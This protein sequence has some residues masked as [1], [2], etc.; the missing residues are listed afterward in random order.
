MQNSAFPQGP[1]ILDQELTSHSDPLPVEKKSGFL[2]EP[3]DEYRF[4][5]FHIVR[6]KKGWTG[7][8]MESKLFGE[9]T[10]T[11]EWNKQSFIFE[12]VGKKSIAVNRVRFD[13]LCWSEWLAKPYV[14]LDL[15]SWMDSG[16][17]VEF[18]KVEEYKVTYLTS[19]KLN[20][21]SAEWILITSFFSVDKGASSDN[22]YGRSPAPVRIK[23]NMQKDRNELKQKIENLDGKLAGRLTNGNQEI[24]IKNRAKLLISKNGNPRLISGLFLG[25]EFFLEG[26]SVAAVQVYPIRR[27][28]KFVRMHERLDGDLEMAVATAI[29]ALLTEKY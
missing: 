12:Q 4:G 29:A 7:E 15:S 2:S 11:K 20:P 23:I 1:I 25:Y 18:Y 9:A 19:F 16:F 17:G 22:F 5:S 3:I 21:D 8:A 28:T 24:I 13:S 10:H 26:K 14:E 6:G 27:D